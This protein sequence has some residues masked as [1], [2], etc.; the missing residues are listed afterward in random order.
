MRDPIL[1]SLQCEARLDGDEFVIN[2]QKTWTTL[3]QD[4][5]HIFLLVRTDKTVKQQAGISFLLVDMQAPGIQ[6]RPIR[7]L[8]GDEEFCEVFFDDVRVP[9]E[10]LVGELNTGW[11]IAK[12]L[13]GFERIFLGSPKQSQYALQRLYAMAEALGLFQDAAFRDR[14]TGLRLKVMDLESIY[15][16][17]A[18]VVKTGGTLG[19]DVSML[20]IWATETFASLTELMLEAAGERGAERGELAFTGQTVNVLSQFYNAR[21]ATIYGGSNEIQRNI[22]SKHVL[23]L[24]DS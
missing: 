15:A 18:E 8:A 11:S 4:A 5:T 19:P 14:F 1:A 22:L 23:R 6:L 16:R 3:A 17:F 7:N 24:P 20:K 10:N 13:L 9:T 2:G 12:A 21:P